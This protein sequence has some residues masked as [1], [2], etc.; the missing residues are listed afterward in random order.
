MR[1]QGNQLFHYEQPE[2][3]FALGS[4]PMI[5]EW[6]TCLMMPSSYFLFFILSIE[7]TNF[8]TNPGHKWFLLFLLWILVVSLAGGILARLLLKI[9]KRFEQ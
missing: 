9:K 1:S 6:F 8:A 2:P 4:V 5:H 3:Y 7:K